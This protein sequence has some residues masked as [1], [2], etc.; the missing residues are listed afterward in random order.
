MPGFRSKLNLR[1]E[2]VGKFVIQYRWAIILFHLLLSALLLSE[3]PK[4]RIITTVESLFYPQDKTLKDYHEFRDQFGRGDTIILLIKSSDI[5]TVSFLTHLKQFHEDLKNSVPFLNQISSLANARYLV[6][7]QGQ[8]VIQDFLD[9]LPES[10][11]EAIERKQLALNYPSYKGIY[12]TEDL[13]HAIVSLKTEAVSRLSEDGKRISTFKPVGRPLSI[14]Q[15][16]NSAILGVVNAVM[17]EYNSKDFQIY[18]SGTPAYQSHVEPLLKSGMKNLSILV[19][20]LTAVFM[21]I[22]FGRVSG[23]FLPQFIVVL[24][25]ILT[26]GLMSLNGAS[27]TSTTSMLPA[28]LLSIGLTAPIHF[29][30]VFFKFQVEGD[31]LNAIVSTLGHSGFPITM[32]SV[33]TAAGFLSFSF[34]DIAPV[35]DLGIYSALG[36][37]ICLSLTLFLLPAL[38]AVLKIR[39]GKAREKRYEQ[40]AYNRFLMGV[41]RLSVEHPLKTVLIAFGIAIALSS[42][43]LKI[44]FSH[45]MLDYLLDDSEFKKTLQLIE[46][47]TK[48]FR[49]LEIIVDTGITNG[50]LNRDLLGSL[51]KIEEYVLA[52]RS[53]DGDPM[54]GKTVSLLDIVKEINQVTH[55]NQKSHYKI[56]AGNDAIA[57]HLQLLK[58]SQLADLLNFTDSNFQKA[59]FS[60][61]MYWNDAMEDVEF[62]T[63]L[64]KVAWELFG[65][66]NTVIVTGEVTL[67]SRTFSSMMRS[68]SLSYLAAFLIITLLMILLIGE[69]KMGLISMIPNLLPVITGL[70]IMG[71]LD[72]PLNTFNL[73]AGSVVM[74]LAVDDT[75]HFFHNFQVYYSET[76]DVKTAV[77]K[78]LGST[79]RALLTTTLILV[80]SFWLRLFNPLKVI[81]D[82]G[83]IM[84]ISLLIA[85]LADVAL[86][87]ALLKLLLEGKSSRFATTR[88]HT[89]SESVV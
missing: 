23:V 76:G 22:L 1:F 42:G 13:R 64:E 45:H 35:A 70:G 82:S 7:D 3:L 47:E 77:E 78:T 75:I 30:V 5:F 18:M 9:G 86:A 31:R 51:E 43:I 74:G 29:M 60:A 6:E 54:V 11:A 34:T 21:S 57:R 56:P 87:P 28:F 81:S 27:L 63:R 52:Q 79:G 41:G 85:F 65:K 69:L 62:V 46:K 33:T 72:I 66:N 32:T 67:G 39:P 58:K 61:K 4:L 53:S 48:G 14:S 44:N 71:L 68:L 49:S 15:I 25:L 36:V 12:F 20:V 24:G 10:S 50:V 17:Q 26:L 8:T 59:R 80:S 83:L 19:L 40:S 38:I 55:E 73:I 2:S 37:I 84:G 89:S 16:E 88:Q